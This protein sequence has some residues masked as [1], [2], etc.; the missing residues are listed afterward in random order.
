MRSFFSTLLLLNWG[1]LLVLLT[2]ALGVFYIYDLVV[3]AVRPLILFSFVLIAI[4]GTFYISTNIAMRITDPLATV[5]KKTK[6]INA[7]DFGV[8]LSSPDIREL[9]TLASSINEMARR[10]KLQFL[11]L[12]VEKEKFNY[13]LQNLKEGVFAIDRNHKFLFLNRNIS[14]T[15]IQKNS[16][17]KEFAPSIKNKELLSFITD[18]ILSGKE[19]KTEFQDGLHFY[20]A[21]IY[22]IKSDAMVQL[23]IGVI[24]DI[25]EDRQNQLIREQFFQNASHELKTPITSIKGYAETLEYKLKLQP[26]SNE[27]KFLDAILRNTDRLIR[28]VEDMLTVSRLENHKTVLNLTDVSLYEL[29]KNVSE[30]LGVIYSQKKQN[31]VLEIP[32][33]LKVQAD[34]LLLEDL[35]VNL[36]SNASAYSPEGASVIVKAFATKENNLIQVIDHGIGISAEDADRIFERF[37]RVDTNRSRKEGGTGLGLSIVKHIARLH[38]G[39]VNVAPN[40]KGGSIFSFVF[41][42]K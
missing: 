9:A 27:R 19:G 12:T 20:T 29:V 7:G 35:L 28:I 1:L 2:L 37:F 25:T 14:E 11:D 23:Y 5:E 4:F 30:S 22:P 42:K 36:I 10:L 41:P 38:S 3:P 33:D 16:Q 32:T 34:R 13:L 8:E 24:S 31:L 6:E 15:L 39:E 40:P 21:R 26:E 17:F 18:K